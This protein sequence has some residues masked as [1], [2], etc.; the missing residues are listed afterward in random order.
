MKFLSELARTG[1]D[2][3]V[4]GGGCT[5]TGILRDLAMRGFKALLLEQGDLAHGSS[6]RF[7]GLL[8]S[9]GRYAVFDPAAAR[10]CIE[11]NMILRRI[12][13][14]C[15]EVT[16]GLFVRTREDDEVFEEKWVAACGACGIRAEPL[17]RARALE[18]EP[19]LAPDLA[20]AYIVPDSAV[21]GFRLVWQNAFSARRHGGEFRT[22]ACVS[23]IGVAQGRVTGV[24]A[25]DTDT[26]ETAFIP[27]SFVV[28]ATGSWVGRIAQMAGLSVHVQPDRGALV[29]FNHRFTGRVVNRLHKP[30]DG[31]IFVPHGS[32]TI[33]GTSSL[34][35]EDP[36]DSRVTTE[37]VLHLL[38]TGRPLFPQIDS[39]RILR[40]F[41]GTRP[42]YMA[43]DGEGGRNASR[44]F[45]VL[46]HEEEGLSGIASVCGGKFTTYRLMAERMVDLVC[47]RLG[48]KAAC[49]TASEPLVPEIPEE[50][51]RRA[52]VFFPAQGLET[53][54]S[55]LCDGLEGA[56]A[57]MEL[58][59]WKKSLVCECEV[60]TF[61][62]FEQMAA[63]PSSRTLN[64]IRRRTRL[65]MG[66][67]QGTFCGMRAIGRLAEAGMP[68]GDTSMLLRD[69]QEERWHGFRPVL[70]GGELRELEL[71]RNVYGATL[72]IDGADFDR[73]DD[74][75]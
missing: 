39:Y 26:A 60:V 23:D 10:E 21:D 30:G 29:A 42:L 11:E 34:K 45:V 16:E 47:A 70:W 7:H 28:N 2:V 15:V 17:T 43:S 65:G 57:R 56:V 55:R 52:S 36:A 25:C 62:E 14:H 73:E 5:G 72:N 66:T 6:S 13:A 69:F 58:E 59:P 35:T 71:A 40:V 54:A 68:A 64:D 27:A 38:D 4:I 8:H 37:E 20:S 44:N 18:L 9:G 53:A 48:R 46:D 3:I 19:N 24:V 63:E 32:I 12:G 51:R 41:A 74:C 67:C 33:L 75:A 22:R 61:G 31:D 49:T 1:W 50:L